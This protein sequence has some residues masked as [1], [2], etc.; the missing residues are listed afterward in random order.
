MLVVALTA[1][2]LL[3]GAS[4]AP[5][6][7]TISMATA[8][9]PPGFVWAED[10]VDTPAISPVPPSSVIVEEDADAV[11]KVVCARLEAAATKAIAEK[12]SFALAIP[13]GSILKMLA[14][15]DSPAW[16]AKTWMAYVN[17]KC[18]PMDD[19]A[20]ATHAK[21]RA[22]FLAGWEEQGA[23][24]LVMSGGAD[25]AAEAAAYDEAM[26]ALPESTL[27][28]DAATGLPVFDMMLIGVGDDG[29]VGSLYPGRPEVEMVRS[30]D[31]CMHACMQRT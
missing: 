28:R 8:A 15:V 31:A 26:K 22:L 24:V 20:L 19:A 3:I 2:G 27:P 18:V 25:A 29:H 1:Y 11:A 7:S 9:P 23:Q 4:V 14:G 21:A 16:A 30:R 10:V 6:A 13:G 17:H 12:G 5:R